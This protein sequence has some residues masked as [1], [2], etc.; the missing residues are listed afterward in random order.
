[1]G[2]RNAPIRQKRTS[3][4]HGVRTIQQSNLTLVVWLLVVC[5]ENVETSLVGRELFLHL[6]YCH[7]FCLLDYPE[8]E[9]LSLYYE[10]VLVTNL[11][12]D[13][14]DGVAWEARNDTVNECCANV[15]VVGK[16][17]LETLV[18]STHI[19]L[20]KLDIL[21]DA[22]L[23]VVTVQ[24]NQLT[25]HQDHTLGRIALEELVTV[26]QQLNQL[27]WVRSCRS[28]CKLARVVERNTCLC[29][30]RNAFLAALPKP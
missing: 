11:L 26:E 19:F 29:C 3:A 2:S 1:M 25:R 17:L 4:Q 27:T 6:L 14:L 9:A 30:V 21:V 13:F 7:V 10:V 24:E 16:P 18:V 12:L 20:P 5:Y 8:V 28:I 15:A 23:Q 22:F